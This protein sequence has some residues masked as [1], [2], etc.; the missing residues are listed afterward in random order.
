MQ[1]GIDRARAGRVKPAKALL[2]G[3]YHVVAVG[4]LVLEQVQDHVLQVAL[5]EHA[6]PL[7]AKAETPS[8]TR[9]E[10]LLHHA[11]S[12]HSFA[13]L[14]ITLALQ[15]PGQFLNSRLSRS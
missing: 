12:E 3:P 7:R 13:S 6:S 9:A 8:S 14:R 2:Q 5:L 11:W 4:G 15:R 10:E 1:G